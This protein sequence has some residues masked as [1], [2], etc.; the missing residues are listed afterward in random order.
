VLVAGEWLYRRRFD[1]HR[2]Y[3]IERQR[4]L[5]KRLRQRELAIERAERQRL[6]RIAKAKRDKLIADATAWRHANDIRAL[7]NAMSQGPAPDPA[8]ATWALEEAN[9]MDPSLRGLS[10]ANCVSPEEADDSTELSEDE[11]G[12]DRVLPSTR[13]T[14]R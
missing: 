1:G 7:V 13:P 12:S 2:N 4:E 6:E 9:R 8:W 14:L 5:Q 11:V 10:S 3:L